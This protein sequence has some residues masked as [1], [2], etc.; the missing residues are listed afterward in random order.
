MCLHFN[1]YAGGCVGKRRQ[2][3][4]S[5]SEFCFRP[6]TAMAT[7][8]DQPGFIIDWNE[9]HT[10]TYT[11]ALDYDKELLRS[12]YQQKNSDHSHKA[13]KHANNVPQY[14]RKEKKVKKARRHMAFVTDKRRKLKAQ[15]QLK[16]CAIA[17]ASDAHNQD[18]HAING[19]MEPECVCFSRGA[20]EIEGRSVLVWVVDAWYVGH[21]EIYYCR[22]LSST[23]VDAYL[24]QGW[25]AFRA[26]VQN[27]LMHA[28]N[29]NVHKAGS[30]A[31]HNAK[32]DR[33]KPHAV[34]PAKKLVIRTSL[35]PKEEK[36]K[37]VTNAPPQVMERL[38]YEYGNRLTNVIEEN[39]FLFSE[40]DADRF[41]E[42]GMAHAREELHRQYE[43]GEPLTL[44]LVVDPRLA[45]EQKGIPI[46]PPPEKVADAYEAADS[47]GIPQLAPSEEAADQAAELSFRPKIHYDPTLARALGFGPPIPPRPNAGPPLPPR[48]KADADSPFPSPSAPPIELMAQ[49]PSVVPAPPRPPMLP[50]ELSRSNVVLLPKGT[51]LPPVYDVPNVIDQPLLD[52]I[53]PNPDDILKYYQHIYPAKTTQL[54]NVTG[55]HGPQ[56]IVNMGPITYEPFSAHFASKLTSTLNVSNR[57]VDYVVGFYTYY[58]SDD[59]AYTD[60]ALGQ[61]NRVVDYV[62]L[63]TPTRPHYVVFMPH[64]LSEAMKNHSIHSNLEAFKLNCRAKISQLP[65]LPLQDTDYVQIVNGTEEVAC[66]LA[67][68]GQIGNLNSIPLSI[69]ANRLLGPGSGDGSRNNPISHYTL[70][71]GRCMRLVT[72]LLR[73]HYLDRNVSSLT[74]RKYVQVIFAALGLGITVCSISGLFLGMGQSLLIVRTLTRLLGVLRSV[75]SVIYHLLTIRSIP[76]L[77][78]S[79]SN[80]VESTYGHWMSC[81]ISMLGYRTRHIPLNVKL[82]SLDFMRKNSPT[83]LVISADEMVSECMEQT[84]CDHLTSQQLTSLQF[85]KMSGKIRDLVVDSFKASS[86]VKESLNSQIAI[87][88]ENSRDMMNGRNSGGSTLV[89][90][91][92]K[93]FPDLYFMLLK[94]RFFDYLSSQ[95]TLLLLSGSEKLM[96][97]INLVYMHMKTIISLTSRRL[98]HALCSPSKLSSMPTFSDEYMIDMLELSL[99]HCWEST[100]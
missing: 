70:R 82:N 72:G 40:E 67:Y 31:R 25:Q 30:N 59:T 97:C 44:S 27:R 32:V 45:L 61:F 20:I 90:T 22:V 99:Q 74:V 62:A 100:S 17:V 81:L 96:R 91:Y 12:Q 54:Q 79:L 3:A 34:Q 35:R 43:R 19:N 48:P 38:L 29:G 84:E 60:D 8:Y 10:V 47:K 5:L 68:A 76:P 24:N 58:N 55:L 87:P 50:R 73:S 15:K 92:L 11:N 9:T 94:N 63:H 13:P 65:S 75:C 51:P 4:P 7:T 16:D 71:L 42:E 93:L 83:E 41:M 21:H 86:L 18:I 56:F 37:A 33:K 6:N 28:T 53:R 64:L 1:S 2:I 36:R 23:D 88:S 80:G 85:C 69:N 98:W 14:S 52:G 95:S 89:M 49:P 66:A 57:E 77:Q 39:G 46:P 26:R 78:T